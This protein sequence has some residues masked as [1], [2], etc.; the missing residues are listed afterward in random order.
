MKEVEAW[1]A[2]KLVVIIPEADEKAMKKLKKDPEAVAGHK[3]SIANLTE[4]LQKTVGESWKFNEEKE[5]LTAKQAK[6]VIKNRGKDLLVMWY[7]P[8]I[9]EEM[10]KNDHFCVPAMGFSRGET[11]DDEKPEMTFF[12]PYSKSSVYDAH[13]MAVDFLESTMRG[14][15][16]HVQNQLNLMAT[17]K[18]K[19]A[20]AKLMKDDAIKNCALVKNV[21]VY[22]DTNQYEAWNINEKAMTEAFGKIKTKHADQ[23]EIKTAL[24]QG[25]DSYAFLV[26]FPVEIKKVFKGSKTEYGIQVQRVLMSCKDGKMMYQSMSQYGS[27]SNGAPE[28]ILNDFKAIGACG[29]AQ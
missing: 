27:K 23:E 11:F 4:L 6:S 1:K 16:F 24:E 29:N 10:D 5:F 22:L 17:N 9:P 8:I 15:V 28:F 13:I 19:Q 2:R 20:I 21:V 14:F 7:V 18:K 26:S 12:L 3:A 25:S